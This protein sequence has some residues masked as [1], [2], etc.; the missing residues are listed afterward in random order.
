M[1]GGLATDPRAVCASFTQFYTSLYS[2]EPPCP[3][4]TQSVLSAVDVRLSS[5]D[6]EVLDG[7]LTVAEVTAAVAHTQADKSPGLDGLTGA[8]YKAFP[9]IVKDLTAALND[10]L[11]RGSLTPSQSTALMILLFKKG[12]KTE[13]K[14]YRPI[15]LLCLDYRILTKVLT[16]R[17][18]KVIGKLIHPSQT[19]VPGRR[20]EDTHPHHPGHP[21]LLRP[22]RHQRLASHAGPRKGL[23]SSGLA[24]P[25]G[26]ASGL[27]LRG[28]FPCGH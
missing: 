13:R 8:F 3:A 2:S 6:C 24:V 27:R 4:A 5:E 7:P 14:N 11:G 9:A 20:I 23:R 22:A 28:Y 12:D 1:W 17:L 26:D 19:A 18:R 16:G 15:S 25:A 10:A 21:G